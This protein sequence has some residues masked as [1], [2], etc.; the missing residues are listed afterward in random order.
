MGTGDQPSKVLGNPHD[1]SPS[2]LPECELLEIL[3]TTEFPP[4][5]CRNCGYLMDGL[6]ALADI[7]EDN[8]V[9]RLPGEGDLALCLDCAEP[10]ILHGG[11]FMQLTD[12][13]LIDMPFEM[14]KE[15]SEAQVA[16]RKMHAE[17]KRNEL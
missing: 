12:D 11:K 9:L 15:M 6:K 17:R 4:W 2:P 8:D 1:V 10:H 7:L 13:E 16:I 14:K 3:M 5:R